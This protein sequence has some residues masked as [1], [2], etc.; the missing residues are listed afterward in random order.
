MH[1]ENKKQR[2]KEGTKNEVE[3]KGKKVTEKRNKK[4]QKIKTEMMATIKRKF[5]RYYKESTENVWTML[6]H[7]IKSNIRVQ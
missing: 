3:E 6:K 2:E 4:S 5:S 7:T 1:P